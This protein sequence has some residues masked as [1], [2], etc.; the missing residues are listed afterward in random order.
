MNRREAENKYGFDMRVSA[1]AMAAIDPNR[2]NS[3]VIRDVKPVQGGPVFRERRN[4]A[5]A[6]LDEVAKPANEKT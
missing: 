2:G 1:R 5:L 6:D 4:D 3:F